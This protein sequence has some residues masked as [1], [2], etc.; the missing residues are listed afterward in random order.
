LDALLNSSAMLHAWQSAAT[1]TTP[2][3]GL[4]QGHL[5]PLRS[6]KELPNSSATPPWALPPLP[7]PPELPLDLAPARD[8]TVDSRRQLDDALLMSSLE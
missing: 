8:C 6:L 3:C 2:H 1:A 4:K 5:L 7:P